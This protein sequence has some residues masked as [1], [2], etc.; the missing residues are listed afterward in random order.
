M[1]AQ[2]FWDWTRY[3]YNVIFY[4][5]PSKNGVK[6]VWASSGTFAYSSN[7]IRDEYV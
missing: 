4:W 3:Q 6:M 1:Y 5:F 2:L 7:G